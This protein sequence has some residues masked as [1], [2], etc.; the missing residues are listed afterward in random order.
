MK[1]HNRNLDKVIKK[2]FS[3]SDPQLAAFYM[4]V[5]ELP[6]LWENVRG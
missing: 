4:F 6:Q 2:N 1:K 5:F 3:K